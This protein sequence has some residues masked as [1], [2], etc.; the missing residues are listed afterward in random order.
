LKNRV[1]I[2]P[3]LDKDVEDDSVLIDGPP[4]IMDHAPDPHEDLVEMPSVTGPW[5]PVP[6]AVR[7]TLAELPAPPPYGLIGDDDAT[8]REN[9]FD[10]TEAEA[11]YVIQPDGMA[12]DLGWKAVA[13]VRVGRSFHAIT[14]PHPWADGQTRL[15]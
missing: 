10:V 11:E 3:A 8:F 6:H 4:Q 2:A 13:I 5:P 9:Q 14:L 7:E 1:A 12:D 15:T